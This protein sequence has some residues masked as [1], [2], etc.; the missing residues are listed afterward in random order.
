MGEELGIPDAIMKKEPSAGLWQGQ[1]DEKEI[2]ISYAELDSAL[3]SLEENTWKAENEIQERV[4]SLV[5]K[6]AHK[7]L[8]ALSLAGTDP[9]S[10]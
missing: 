1:S 9:R 10:L 6:S 4:L 8:P 7:R 2:G 5:K 3:A